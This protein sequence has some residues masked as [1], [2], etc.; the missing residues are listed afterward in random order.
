[1]DSWIRSRPENSSM[2]PNHA[3]ELIKEDSI[4]VRSHTFSSSLNPS[5]KDQSHCGGVVLLLGSKM[6]VGI[7]EGHI[8]PNSYVLSPP[9]LTTQVPDLVYPI[10]SF[11]LSRASSTQAPGIAACS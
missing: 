6:L 7:H 2:K 5:P 10:S 9:P 4:V 8:R 1:M 3:N 11:S